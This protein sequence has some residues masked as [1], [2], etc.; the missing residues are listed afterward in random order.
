MKNLYVHIGFPRTATKILQLRLFKKHNDLNYL[1]RFSDR[2]PSHNP[3]ISK[4]LSYDE[5]DLLRILIT[6]L[7]RLKLTIK[8]K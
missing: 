3:T 4:I 5:E 7:E 1:G 2:V 6:Y 8:F